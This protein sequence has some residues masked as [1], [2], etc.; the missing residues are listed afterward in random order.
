MK[1]KLAI[2]AVVAVFSV[3][4][5]TYA[6]SPQQ[7]DAD[8]ASALQMA[9]KRCERITTCPHGQRGCMV[10]GSCQCKASSARC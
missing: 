8:I 3:S 5:L 10:A 6:R 9:H 7:R 2:L 4:N 1:I